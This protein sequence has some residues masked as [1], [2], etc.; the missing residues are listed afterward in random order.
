M[1][2]NRQAPYVELPVFQGPMDLLLHLIQQ[3]KVDIYD[4]PIALI[5]DQFIETVKKMEIFDMEITSEFL[6]LAA[7]LLYLKSRQLLPRPQKSEEDVELEEELKQELIDRLV[8]Y[9]AFKEIAAYLSCK[10]ESAGSKYFREFDLD[11][12]I[13]IMKPHRPLSGVVMEDLLQAFNSVLTRIEKGEDIHY[14][15]SD[16][17]SIDLMITDIMRRMLINPKGMKFSQLLRH[18]SRVE[19]VVAFLAILDLLKDGKIRAEQSSQGNGIF[20]VP[21]EKAWDFKN[22]VPV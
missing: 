3:N 22:E 14:V 8:T 2:T 21:T 19:I 1:E 15:Q 20:I 11:E 9:R 6:V 10:A 4:I 7:Q 17:I 16:D 13:S 5:A 12:L 18:N